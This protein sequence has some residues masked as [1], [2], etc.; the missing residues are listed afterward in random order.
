L[1]QVF[2]KQIQI[3]PKVLGVKH[4]KTTN[5]TKEEK[6]KVILDFVSRMTFKDFQFLKSEE[7]EE[8]KIEKIK[9]ALKQIQ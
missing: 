6:A 2:Y 3:I 4:I 8:I 7:P 9:K 5:M 1:K